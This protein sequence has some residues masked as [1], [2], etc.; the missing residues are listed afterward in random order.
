MYQDI[1]QYDGDDF[2]LGSQ[3]DKYKRNVETK[4]QIAIGNRLITV[5]VCF[6]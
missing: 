6:N 4:N 1:P 2:P 3:S 5:N